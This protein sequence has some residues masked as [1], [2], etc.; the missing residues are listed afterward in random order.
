MD[1]WIADDFVGALFQVR[2][3][4]EPSPQTNA[5]FFLIQKLRNLAL[6][7]GPA[8]TVFGSDRGGACH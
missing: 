2:D 6:A 1:Y 4:P 3:G 5:I 7:K 8:A